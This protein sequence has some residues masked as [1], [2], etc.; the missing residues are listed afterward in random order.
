[1]QFDQLKRREFITLLGGA[2]GTWPLTAHAQQTTRARRLGVLMALAADDAETQV[3]LAALAQ[4]LQQLGWT[5]SQNL[6][7]DYRWGSSNAEI[8]RKN[9]AELIALVPDIILA[10]SRADSGRFYA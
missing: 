10:H 9:A 8:M 3:R 1:M 6:K 4:G 7:V 2:A 5:I